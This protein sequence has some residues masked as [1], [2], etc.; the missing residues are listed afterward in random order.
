MAAR[1]LP[2]KFTSI[3]VECVATGRRHDAHVVALVAVVD[4]NESVLCNKKVKVTEPVVSYLTPLT[5]LRADDGEPLDSVLAEVKRILHPDVVLVGQGIKNDVQWL[6]LREGKD[7]QSTVDLGELFK[8]YNPR[9]RNYSFFSLSHEAN[10]LL[11]P[12][13]YGASDKQGWG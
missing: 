2:E 1:S 3:D 9:F 6:C 11:C 13:R 7:F 10:L 4:Q 12:G 5:G 8:T